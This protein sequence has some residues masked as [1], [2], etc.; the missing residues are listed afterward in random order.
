MNSI[1]KTRTLK[2]KTLKME[3]PPPL[4]ILYSVIEIG[5]LKV[6]CRFNATS[7]KILAFFRARKQQNP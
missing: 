5:V 3:R 1:I 2:K 6:D 7:I 4:L